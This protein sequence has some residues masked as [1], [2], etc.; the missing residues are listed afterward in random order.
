MSRRK[1]LVPIE[2]IE[3]GI[4]LIRGQRV[5]LDADLAGLYGVST[6]RL[7]EQVRRN[8][9]RFPEDFMFQ[10]T[11]NEKAEVV[12]NCDHLAK[13]KFSPVLPNAFTE[14]GAIMVASVLNTQRA[15][16]VSVF[17][18]RAFVKLREIL[19]TH[20]ELAHKLAALE[21]KLQN[22]D[23]SIRSLVAAIRQL[24]AQPE[25]KK[26]PIGFLVEEAKVPYLTKIKRRS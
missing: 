11:T 25:S 5:M 24:M 23:E 16:Q 19:S 2:Q 9:D 18:V 6:K 7:N 14:H 20:K 15:V 17:V 4:L 3:Q 13:L 21:R 8:Q 12:A 1:A 10:L 22:H 26:R